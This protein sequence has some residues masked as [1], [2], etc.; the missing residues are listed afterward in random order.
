MNHMHVYTN[1]DVRTIWQERHTQEE[2]RAVAR[3]ALVA[4]AEVLTLQLEGFVLEH[5][6][7]NYFYYDK[8]THADR[9]VCIQNTYDTQRKMY[10]TEQNVLHMALSRSI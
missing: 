3:A 2:D 4:A 6:K 7:I 9:Q 1:A 10:Y 5:P 8:A